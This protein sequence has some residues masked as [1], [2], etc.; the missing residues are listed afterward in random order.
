[1]SE[2]VHVAPP[3]GMRG[4]PGP[5]LSVVK[6]EKIA[7]VL[8]GMANT[9]IGF[10]F[11]VLFEYTVGVLFGYLV[12]LACAHVA[13]VLCAF[14][15]YRHL[16][17]RVRGHVW[18]DLARFELVYLAALAVNFVMLPLLVELAHI[19]PI[20]AQALIVFVTAMISY[21]GH[22]GFSFRRPAVKEQD[23]PGR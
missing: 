3:A 5:L 17:F 10:L 1:M 18:R 19:P 13:S 22:K 23:A 12:T 14:V 9:G 7:F 6:N 21:F 8:V 2:D 16:V 4:S 15:L 11:F 20:P